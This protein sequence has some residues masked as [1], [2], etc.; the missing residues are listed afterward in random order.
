MH[1]ENSNT[2]TT[3][4]EGPALLVQFHLSDRNKETDAGKNRVTS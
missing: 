3:V 4:A 1:K 2:E